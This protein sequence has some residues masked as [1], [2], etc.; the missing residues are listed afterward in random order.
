MLKQLKEL[1]ANV[2]AGSETARMIESKTKEWY[3]TLSF[4]QRKRLKEDQLSEIVDELLNINQK[5]PNVELKKPK[6]LP[7]NKVQGLY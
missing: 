3:N 6:K 7:E 1:A 2:Q 5:R 4:D